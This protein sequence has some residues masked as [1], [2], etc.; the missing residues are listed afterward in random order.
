MA[1]SNSVQDQESLALAIE[2]NNERGALHELTG[3]IAKAGGDITWVAILDSQKPV[4]SV[5]F[6][7]SGSPYHRPE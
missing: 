3:I 2:V 6:E 4:E 1:H 7:I 5:F